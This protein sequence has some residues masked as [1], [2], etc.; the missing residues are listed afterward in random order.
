MAKGGE[1]VKVKCSH[2]GARYSLPE[3]R[4]RGRVLKIRCKSC[5]EVFEVRHAEPT[6][7]PS[8][9][10]RGKRWFLVVKRQRIGPVTAQ[11]V[12]ERFERG[13]V[14]ATTYAWRQGFSKWQR[15]K[16]IEEFAD[17]D[18]DLAGAASEAAPIAEPRRPT[19]PVTGPAV[20][21]GPLPAVTAAHIPDEE[22]TD[23]SRRPPAGLLDGLS[24]GGLRG[25]KMTGPPQRLTGGPL[26]EMPT[27]PAAL[28][29]LAKE[30]AAA[31]GNDS[32]LSPRPSPAKPPLLR[33]GLAPAKTSRLTGL[34]S[35]HGEG[36]RNDA[37]RPA[38]EQR[39]TAVVAYLNA[40]SAEEEVRAKYVPRDGSG[41]R[42][43]GR[44]AADSQEDLDL[45][46]T[47]P[48]VSKT[49]AGEQLADTSI[50]DTSIG[51]TSIADRG[52]SAVQSPPVHVH[53]QPG[54][55]GFPD[56]SEFEAMLD[57]L[58]VGPGGG[59]AAAAAAKVAAMEGRDGLEGLKKTLETPTSAEL[60]ASPEASSS[61]D[62]A[63]EGGAP[64]APEP[65]DVTAVDARLPS[66]AEAGPA[67]PMVAAHD[68]DDDDFEDDSEPGVRTYS[69]S[70]QALASQV[71]AASAPRVADDVETTSR[72]ERGYEPPL[73]ASRAENSVLFSLPHLVGAAPRPQPVPVAVQ[74]PEPVRTVP[75]DFEVKP[76]AGDARPVLLPDPDDEPR[77]A[78]RGGAGR[79]L[80]VAFV[81]VVFGAGALL[82]GLYAVR[83]DVVTSLF[84]GSSSDGSGSATAAT[85]GGG[86]G[87]GSA[88][89]ASAAAGSSGSAAG[90]AG[91][92][93]AAMASG[94]GSGADD[95]SGSGS[96]AGA[97]GASTAD[98]AAATPPD[99]SAPTKLARANSPRAPAV[100]SGRA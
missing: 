92:G 18:S 63:V 53:G 98:A 69:G 7:A 27:R 15:L 90:S 21:R 6:A 25:R 86:S 38:I 1:L 22:N 70:A 8:L 94:S 26:P 77:A 48:N 49:R 29:G 89:A 36:E 37:G 78:K 95:G 45:D 87:A 93:S 88:A 97:A 41:A 42:A 17:L 68:R 39:D 30:L 3:Q 60:A 84:G 79:M 56:D 31:G 58:E 47:P 34:T 35:H 44:A 75:S 66:F 73:V 20:R 43:A 9:A 61:V 50:G 99:A 72:D 76:I 59:A 54:P 2:C 55:E 19:G 85:A 16:H 65:H 12:R 4:I 67:A 33:G 81:G 11:E 14:K 10:S 24:G 28:E 83:P 91:A 64:M 62:F 52:P 71:Q 100:K 51:D 80:A 82:G 40:E 57:A 23:V 96:V 46:H 5:G 74:E 13:E 32:A